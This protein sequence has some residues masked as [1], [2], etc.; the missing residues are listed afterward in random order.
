MIMIQNASRIRFKIGSTC[1]D[2]NFI[3]FKSMEDILICLK[4]YCYTEIPKHE[5]IS[6]RCVPS[7]P[8]AVAG[9]GVCLRGVC[10]GGV[11]PEGC[12]AREVSGQGGVSLG[13]SAQVVSAGRGV[14]PLR[15]RDRHCPLDP[16]ADTPMW[17][18]FLTYACE[19]ITFP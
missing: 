6:V 14:H 16:E 11:C 19:S 1:N 9:G 4:Y 2:T 13:V 12:L 8:V 5:C 18:E 3:H 7:A 15:S 10:L 17:T